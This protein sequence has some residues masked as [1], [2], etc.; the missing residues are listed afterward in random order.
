[1]VRHND[2]GNGRR[3]N[4]KNK[5]DIKFNDRSVCGMCLCESVGFVGSVGF[6]RAGE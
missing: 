5:V 3:V 1:M 6:V 4:C 2:R